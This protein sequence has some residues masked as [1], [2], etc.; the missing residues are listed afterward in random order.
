MRLFTSEL[1]GEM[2][3]YIVTNHLDIYGCYVG[4]KRHSGKKESR[5]C[6]FY[7]AQC[8]ASLKFAARSLRLTPLSGISV[9]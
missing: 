7:S 3:V 8:S 1:R 5:I 9:T 6:G 4:A 2:N